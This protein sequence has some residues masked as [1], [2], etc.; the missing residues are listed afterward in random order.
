MEWGGKK[1]WPG[2]SDTELQGPQQHVRGTQLQQ[3]GSCAPLIKH[4]EIN[5]LFVRTH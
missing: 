1:R 3:A 2:Q 4:K 5:E